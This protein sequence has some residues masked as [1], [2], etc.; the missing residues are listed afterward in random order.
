M[1]ESA[2]ENESVQ[3]K[4]KEMSLLTSKLYSTRKVDIPGAKERNRL[5]KIEL[6]LG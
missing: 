3:M 5:S 6:A 1:Q 4:R 2:N